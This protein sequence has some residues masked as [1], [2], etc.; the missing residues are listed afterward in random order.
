MFAI[1]KSQCDFKYDINDE[2]N[3]DHIEDSVFAKVLRVG[4]FAIVES[5]CKLQYD[6]DDHN[7]KGREMNVDYWEIPIMIL[8]AT[9]SFWPSIN[10]VR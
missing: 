5:Q 4:M 10:G 3:K 8:I 1:V 7:D 2:N 6:I 9:E